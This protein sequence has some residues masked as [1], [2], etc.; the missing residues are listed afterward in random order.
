MMTRNGEE[1]HDYLD[2]ILSELSIKC[3]FQGH[4]YSQNGTI[5][6]IRCGKVKL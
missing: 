3:A 6:C 4:R 2:N 1:I 5:S